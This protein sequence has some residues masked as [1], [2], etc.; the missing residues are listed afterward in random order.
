MTVRV[1]RNAVPMAVDLLVKQRNSYN[2]IFNILNLFVLRSLE[3]SK[4]T[5]YFWIIVNIMISDVAASIAFF[6]LFNCW[7]NMDVVSSTYATAKIYQVVVLIFAFTSF[8][9]RNCIFALASYERY[10]FICRPLSVSSNKVLNNLGICFVII[11]VGSCVLM[12]VS[13]ATGTEN[14]CYGEFGVMPLKFNPQLDVV[15]GV[16]MTI[17]CFICILCWFRAWKELKKMER[18]N[19]TGGDDLTVRRSAQYIMLMFVMFYL[20]YIPTILGVVFNQVGGLSQ[21]LVSGTRW[22][23]NF[24]QSLYS[25]L[26]VIAYILMT[27]GYRLHIS[28]LFKK[29]SAVAPT[30]NR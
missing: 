27:P 13:L 5:T 20:S 24:Y 16:C 3:K 19:T 17:T 14:Y 18:R 8:M 23:S 7:L 6:F 22:I 29:M 9:T 1:V 21:N 4:R 15:F 2:I 30:G 12:A 11:W 10:I 28:S 25:I 26:N